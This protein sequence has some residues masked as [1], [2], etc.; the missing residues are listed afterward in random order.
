MSRVGFEQV[1]LNIFQGFHTATCGC[2]GNLSSLC[3]PAKFVINCCPGDNTQWIYYSGNKHREQINYCIMDFLLDSK[4][5]LGE[6]QELRGGGGLA[7]P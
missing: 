4:A 6:G 2:E 1:L 7:D 5:S 3:H